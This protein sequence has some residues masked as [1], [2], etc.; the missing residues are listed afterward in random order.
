[1]E[2]NLTPRDLDIFHHL[3]EPIDLYNVKALWLGIPIDDRGTLASK[4]L[5]E[6]LLV[7][8]AL[9]A[10]LTDF[11]ET[12]ETVEDRLR[13]FSALYA[14]MYAQEFSGFLG[15]YFAFERD[16]R[17]VLTALRAKATKR[18]IA[19]E[20]QFEDPSDP[21]VAQI[22]S[23]KDVSEYTPP[24]EYEDLKVLFVENSQDPRKLAEALLKYRFDKVGEWE[25]Q[26]H[27]TLDR[28]L[29]YAARLLMIE[30]IV[31]M[32]PEQT[33]AAMEELNRYG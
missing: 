32:S 20:L 5:E 33:H 9:P 29:A 11:L 25:M 3:L 7:R 23:Q 31:K 10:Y 24:M 6:E 18:D 30:S 27:F 14:G 16:V 12:Y 1:M 26:E 21:K 8:D 19:R 15:W 17:L 2:M 28:I 13:Y 22:L 4:E